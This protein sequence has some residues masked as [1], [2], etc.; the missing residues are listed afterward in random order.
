MKDRTNN[1]SKLTRLTGAKI[2]IYSLWQCRNTFCGV[3]STQ[4]SRKQKETQLYEEENG[5]TE[6]AIYIIYNCYMPVSLAAFKTVHVWCEK[7][8]VWL[9]KAETEWRS[10]LP[11]RSKPVNGGKFIICLATIIKRKQRPIESSDYGDPHG[12]PHQSTHTPAEN[13]TVLLWQVIYHIFFCPIYHCE[14][15]FICEKGVKKSTKKREDL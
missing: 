7:A 9:N 3:L 8:S 13:L 1:L 2:E 5:D 12:L 4:A 6:N 15:C 10:S 11:E 14:I